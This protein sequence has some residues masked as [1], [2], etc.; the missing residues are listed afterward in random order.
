MD[1]ETGK[2]NRVEYHM[3]F[4]IRLP[5]G[6]EIPEVGERL[7]KFWDIPSHDLEGMIFSPAQLDW[8]LLKLMKN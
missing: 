3:F 4:P 1:C 5:R 7:V 2:V 8:R 6:M